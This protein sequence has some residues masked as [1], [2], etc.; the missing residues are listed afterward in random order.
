MQA[1][2]DTTTLSGFFRLLELGREQVAEFPGALEQIRQGELEGVLVRDVYSPELLAGVVERLER[3]DPPFVQTFFPREFQSWFYGRNLN[4]T[5]PQLPGYF[6][7]AARF[8]AQLTELFPYSMGLVAT[9]SQ[10]LRE[11]D[12]GRPFVA[13]PGPQNGEQYMFTTLRAHLQG[14]FIPPHC[15]V[16]PAHPHLREMLQQ[17][18]MSFVLMLGAPEAGGALEIFDE[19]ADTTG[20]DLRTLVRADM[21]GVRSVAFQL[22]PGAMI[23]VDSGRHLHRVSPV[24]GNKKRWTACSFMS[25]SRAGDVSYCWG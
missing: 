5:P 4:L 10:I 16:R 11:L 2:P 14:G 25:L 17:H 12:G 1:R 22:P 24:I 9:T 20:R 7:D 6:Q 15:D 23:V 19:R 18:V 3:H 13:P 21:T 8:H